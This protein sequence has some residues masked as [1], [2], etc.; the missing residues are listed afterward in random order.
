MPFKQQLLAHDGSV[1]PSVRQIEDAIGIYKKDWA[2]QCHA[3]SLAIVKSDLFPKARVARGFAQGVRSQ[4]SWVV[5]SDDCFD[6]KAVIIDATLWSYVA[7]VPII[8]HGSYDHDIHIP[9]GAFHISRTE[10]MPAMKGQVIKLRDQSKMSTLAKQFLKDLNPDGL[11]ANQW[12]WLAAR[13]GV[14]GWPAGEIYTYMYGTPAVRALLPIDRVGMLTNL[15]PGGL[16]TKG[17]AT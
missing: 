16:Y 7:Y 17:P 10:D 4:H 1:I 8:W 3:I 9:H 11:T 2:K 12:H 5:L 14:L 13:A 15:N 6:P